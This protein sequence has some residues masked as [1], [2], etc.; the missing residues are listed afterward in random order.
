MQH[1]RTAF[2][3]LEPP[4]GATPRH[5]NGSSSEHARRFQPL[6]FNQI[7]LSTDPHYLVKGLLPREG[8]A[9]IW[10]PP[11][12][13]KSFWIY[14]LGMHVALGWKYRGRRV[15]AGSVVYI[16][17]EGERGLGARTE[18]FRQARLTEDADP[19]FWLLTTRLDLVRDV[20][21]LIEDV[22]AAIGT[23]GCAL[24]II[25]TLNRSIA[26]SESRDEDMSAYVKAA[27]R[28]REA[29]GGLVALV[30]HCG[31][32]GERPRGHTSLTGAADVQIAVKHDAASLTIATVEHMKD[33]AEGDVIASRLAVVDVGT[34]QDGEA[35]TSC[36]VEPADD[37]TPSPARPK[38]SGI[39][40]VAFDQFKRCMA[41]QAEEL[42]V[43]AHIPTGIRGVTLTYWRGCLEQAGIINR[44]GNPRE[45]FRR[46]RVTLQE[47]GFI[48]VWGEYAWP[49]HRVT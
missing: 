12:C 9:V 2:D 33:G 26:G 20:A 27:D 5:I 13:G 22:R 4:P 24:I 30:H 1:E 6:R 46:I 38:L 36:V 21:E 8:L 39:G 43:S 31:V 48:G 7:R 14:D 28:L 37:I 45:Q 29:F 17:C 18:A 19:P 25:D 44:D 47:R 32:N 23:D 41:D 16:A 42:P 15:R 49:S 34:D 11:K 35:I 3:E 10:G 40:K